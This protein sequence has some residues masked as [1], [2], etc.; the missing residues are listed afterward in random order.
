MK[1]VLSEHLTHSP[2]DDSSLCCDAG[3]RDSS[4]PCG[5]RVCAKSAELVSR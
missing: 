1:G 4:G 3:P 5:A 2:T